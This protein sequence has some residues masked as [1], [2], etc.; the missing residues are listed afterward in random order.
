MS[1]GVK[2][3]LIG[4]RVKRAKPLFKAHYQPRIPQNRDYYDLTDVKVVR[5][6]C[7]IAK[8]YGIDGFAI[9]HYW[10]NGK[11]LMDK[12]LQL[13]LNNKDIDINYFISWA[14]H[15]FVKHGLVATG[16]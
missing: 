5:R 16:M 12:P 8:E 11:L 1:G 10:S 15:D 4:L 13:L 2:D 7:H 3:I 9:Y 14:N 6:Q